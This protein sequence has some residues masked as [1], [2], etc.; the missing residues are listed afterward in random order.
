MLKHHTDTQTLGMA[1]ILHEDLLA[2]PQHLP[3]VRLDHAVY[4]FDQRAFSGTVLAEKCMD[5][6]AFDREGD[7]VVREAAR[8]LLGHTGHPQ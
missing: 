1:G 5:L 6:V 7:T 8:V 3:G 4:R 2:L